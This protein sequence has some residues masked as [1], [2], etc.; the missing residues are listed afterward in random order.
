MEEAQWASGDIDGVALS[1]SCDHSTLEDIEEFDD[2][3]GKRHQRHDKHEDD[4]DGLLRGPKET[5]T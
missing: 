3:Q 2:V 5:V 4:E 1:L